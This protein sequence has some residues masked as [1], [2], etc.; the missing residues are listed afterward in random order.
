[1]LRAYALAASAK[2]LA[3]R[4][5]RF[6]VSGAFGSTLRLFLQLSIETLVHI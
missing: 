4:V 3:D 5:N 6:D 2:V 1:M